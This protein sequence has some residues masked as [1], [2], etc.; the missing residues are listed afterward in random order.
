MHTTTYDR[1]HPDP[2]PDHARSATSWRRNWQGDPVSVATTT[3]IRPL[4]WASL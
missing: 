1:S 3:R 2:T 4:R